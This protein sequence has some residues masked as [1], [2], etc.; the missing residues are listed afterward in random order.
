ML[1]K[2]NEALHEVKNNIYGYIRVSSLEQNEARQIQTMVERGIPKENIF[3]DKLTGKN[4]DR[5]NYQRMKSIL[6]EGDTIVLDSITRLSRN[7]EDIKDEYEYY[8]KNGVFLEFIKEPILNTPKHKVTDIVQIALADVI[9][10]L[11]AA[12]AQKEREDIMIRQREGIAIAKK[13]GKYKGRKPAL[14]EGGKEEVRMQAIIQ[15]YKNGTS[16]EDIRKTF[17]V[18]NWTIQRIL[19]NNG[20]L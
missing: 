3:I 9:L 19:K 11:L 14:V 16:W 13:A 20:L 10:S 5:P 15:A 18:G 2:M 17:K 8:V 6:K 7:Y 4:L 12:F 1:D